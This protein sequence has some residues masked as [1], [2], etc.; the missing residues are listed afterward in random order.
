MT[1]PKIDNNMVASVHYRGTL[2]ESGEEFDCSHGNEPLSYIA[3][4][5]QMIPGFE[6]ALRGLTVGD[7]KTFSLEAE[8]AYGPMNPEGVQEV[9]KDQF[10]P[11]IEVG[12][13]FAAQMPDGNSLPIRV[14]NVA[15]ETVTIDFNH[16]LA[17]QRLTFEVEVMDVR[18]ASE[19]ELSHGHVHGPGGHEH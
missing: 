19:E 8:E 4:S 1:S 18:D 15:D 10:P 11:E 14:T 6:N 16:Q 12:M 2:T 13:V 3:G 9:P 17:G 5:G 7:K